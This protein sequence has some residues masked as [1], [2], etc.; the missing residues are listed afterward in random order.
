MTKYENILDDAKK[1]SVY[2]EEKYPFQ[3]NRIKGLYCDNI[4]AIN[5]CVDTQKEKVCILAEELGHHYTTSRN[6]I[7]ITDIS[8]AKQEQ[9]AR[10]WAYNKLIGLCGIIECY[11]SNCTNRYEMAEHL[12]VTEDF[13]NEAL[14]YYKNKYGTYTTVDNYI[15][16]FEPCVYVLEQFR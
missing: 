15:I 12:E 14:D 11:K 6:I 10:I 3:S 5:R 9:R 4:I 13:L 7:D 8:N 2:I 16:C 1:E